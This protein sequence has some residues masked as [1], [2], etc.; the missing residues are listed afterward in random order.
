MPSPKPCP[1][2]SHGARST[3]RLSVSV[4]VGLILGA[5]LISG[6]TSSSTPSTPSA[7]KDAASTTPA[8]PNEGLTN[9]TQLKPALLTTS[10]LPKG[11]KVTPD[12]TLDSADVFGPK[13]APAKLKKSDCAKLV[14]NA[15]VNGAGIGSAAF[16][17]TGFT[18]SYGNEVDS[19]LDSFRGTQAHQVMTNLRALFKICATFKSKTPGVANTT[20][21]L[22][23]GHG[24]KV[25]DDSL[26]ATL[27]SPSWQGGQTLS[28]VQVGQTVVTVLYSSS[29]GVGGKAVTY[30]KTMAD[31]LS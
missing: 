11:F 13:S 2:A 3:A 29:K 9:G 27:T 10:D 14:T 1:A 30:S 22:V 8:D 7:S 5:V 23:S 16:A 25:G 4:L 31:R 6:C 21:K 28:A 18:D 12:I 15:W 19:E 24:P 17:Q 26:K 20:V